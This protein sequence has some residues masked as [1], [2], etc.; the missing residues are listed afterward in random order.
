MGEVADR[1]HI[2]ERTLRRRLADSGYRFGE[3][4][5]RV[6]RQRATLLLRESD[7]PIGVIAAEVGFSDGREFRRAYARWTGK[8]PSAER[9]A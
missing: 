4:R 6:R 9:S 5:D 8:P 1:L 2:T 3:V 7:Q